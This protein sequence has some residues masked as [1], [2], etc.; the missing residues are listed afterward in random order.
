[1]ELI[2]GVIVVAIAALIWKTRQR[3]KQTNLD[4]DQWILKYEATTSPITQS[5]MAVALLNQSIHLAWTMG[6]IN[7]KQKEVITANLKQQR[8]TTTMMMWL[9][10]A[11]PVI[12]RIVGKNE[13]AN[14]PARAVGVLM[15]LAWMT[16]AADRENVIRQFLLRR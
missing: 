5:G 1:M 3:D 15:L 4:F 16:P 7:S 2:L 11:L 9:G 8:A 10:S 13:V 6:A 12:I 14:T